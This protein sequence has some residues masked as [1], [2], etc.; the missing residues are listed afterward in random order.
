MDNKGHTKS[1]I[2][3]LIFHFWGHVYIAIKI[4]TSYR[5]KIK[6][7]QTNKQKPPQFYAN[8]KK[9]RNVDMQ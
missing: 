4:R 2:Y 8:R 7:K 9:V 3:N 5:N 1:K 6:Q